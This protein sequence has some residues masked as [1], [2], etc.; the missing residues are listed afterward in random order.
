MAVIA[1]EVTIVSP[2]CNAACGADDHRLLPD[3]KMAEPPISPMPYISR[4]ALGADQHMS[5]TS[6]F[7]PN[8][9]GGLDL[10]VLRGPSGFLRIPEA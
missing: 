10:L 4:P 6:S 8:E 5:Y 1:V 7:R 2:C 3:I 9:A